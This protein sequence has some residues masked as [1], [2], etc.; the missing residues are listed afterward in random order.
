MLKYWIF[1][2]FIGGAPAR[3]AFVCTDAGGL[4]FELQDC[5]DN[6]KLGHEALRCVNDYYNHVQAA[7]ADVL[8]KFQEQIAK[9]K[10]QQSDSFDRT[11]EGYANARKRLEALIQE[12]KGARA[13]VDSLQDA[14]VYPEDYDE[15]EVTGQSTEEYLRDQE[16]WS[17]TSRVM[18]QSQ[19]MLDK[20]MNDL[21]TT[22]AAMGGKQNT[23]T[24]RSAHVQELDRTQSISRTKG[25][26]SG[27]PAGK[28]R[29]PASDI[30]GTEKIKPGQ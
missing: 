29:V 22:E 14:M 2:I 28:S 5:D 1:L 21:S 8:R 9:Q 17:V 25:T 10:K 30:T 7:Q 4:P 20:M 18:K 27:I 16:C 26:G 12:G 11:A 6:E 24:V 15:P 13:A 3:A 19:A 23:S